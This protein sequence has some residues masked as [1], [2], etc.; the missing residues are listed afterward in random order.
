MKK[1]FSKRWLLACGAAAVGTVTGWGIFKDSTSMPLISHTKCTIASE[2][3]HTVTH[4]QATIGA[5][6]SQE[7]S[8]NRAIEKSRL[9][10]KRGM[11]ERGIP[12]A[13]VTVCK[14]G[15]L[16]WSEG[17]GYADVENHVLC[18][19]NTVM[20][21]ASISKPLSAVAL[22]QLWQKGLVDLDAPLQ[23]YVPEFPAKTFNG[24]PVVITTRH[25]LS[26]MAGI[27]HYHEL[28]ADQGEVLYSAL[29]SRTINLEVITTPPYPNKY[30]NI[31]VFKISP[32]YLIQNC[33]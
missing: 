30:K 19:P 32:Y 15:R 22:L 18:T 17:L 12:G 7:N 4:L 9:V 16:V 21:I 11:L 24:K 5:P 28:K 3:T 8:L 1:F 20:R 13:V 10:I 25:V 2:P 14:N 31:R 29:E 27:R 23:K 26:N 6:G 33:T